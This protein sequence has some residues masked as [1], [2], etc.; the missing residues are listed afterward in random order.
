MFLLAS[1][2]ACDWAF[3]QGTA[4]HSGRAIE[5]SPPSGVVTNARPLYS[6]PSESGELPGMPGNVRLGNPG[7]SQRAPVQGIVTP[8]RRALE[9]ADDQRNWV[10]LSPEEIM[11]SFVFN[12]ILKTPESEERQNETETSSAIDRFYERLSRP[13][14]PTNVVAGRDILGRDIVQERRETSALSE[15]D[16]Y[17]APR[18]LWS[19]P[20]GSRSDRQ[21]DIAGA[22]G[23]GSLDLADLL[24]PRLT[25]EQLRAKES[26]ELQLREFRQLLNL[27][28]E[29]TMGISLPGSV[30][31]LP[32]S[33]APAGAYARGSLP[34]VGSGLGSLAPFQGPVGAIAPIQPNAPTAPMH[35]GESSLSPIAPVA[36]PARIT[37]LPQPNFSP[38]QRPF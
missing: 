8:G 38:P 18:G 20:F 13:S 35:Y 27:S 17:G 28:T 29:A 5:F 1:V 25:A 33:A 14:N 7:V 12:Q 4:S 15:D 22:D 26:Q 32:T 19:D 23:R 31:G 2:A 37:P 11:Q 24:V 10:F 36:Q 3:G 6:P 9:E 34:P 16:L 21:D 30:P